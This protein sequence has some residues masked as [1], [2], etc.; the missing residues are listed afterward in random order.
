MSFVDHQEAHGALFLALRMRDKKAFKKAAEKLKML[1]PIEEPQTKG[2]AQHLRTTQPK[3]THVV[4]LKA[5]T[6]YI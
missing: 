1:P 6:G 2:N 3:K 5:P 4:T